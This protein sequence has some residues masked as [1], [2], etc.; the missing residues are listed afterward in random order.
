MR[1]V[2]VL[3]PILAAVA[4]VLLTAGSA[5][6][7]G[8][9]M[10]LGHIQYNSPGTD[11]RSNSSLNAEYVTVGNHVTTSRNLRGWTLRDNQSH[12]YTFPNVNVGRGKSVVVHT[13]HGTNTSTNLYWGS[14]N[15][16]WNNTGDRATLR[17]AQGHQIDTCSWGN[18]SGSINC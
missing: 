7:A 9:A 12:V 18:G 13:G 8:F 5:S 10:Q 16:I 11:N 14:G 15:Y 17:D 2:S 4:A 1:R 6:A 3:A